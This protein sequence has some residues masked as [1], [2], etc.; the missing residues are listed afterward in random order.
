MKM[1]ETQKFI[2][3]ILLLQLFYL[4]TIHP[5]IAFNKCFYFNSL[6]VYLSLQVRYF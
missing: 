4:I 6:S 3:F 2:F 1:L 5:Q